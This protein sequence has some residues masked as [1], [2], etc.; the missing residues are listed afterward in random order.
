VARGETQLFSPAELKIY[1]LIS[2]RDGIKAREI[3]RELGLE[4]SEISRWMVSSALMRELCYQDKEY[5]WHAL[6]RQRPPYEGL[7]EFS[8]WY[9]TVPEF[10]A[11]DEETWLNELEQGCRRIGR[12]LND[13]RG[14]IHSFRDCRETMR[15]LF[16]DLREM[17]SLNT[18]SWEIVFE[19]RLNLRRMIRIYA[20][21]LVITPDRVF[22]LE[23]KMKNAVDPA[24]VLQ[25]A[26]YVPYLEILFGSQMD[27]F[28]ALVL[29]GATELFTEAPIGKTDFVLPVCSGDMLFNVFNEAIGFLA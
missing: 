28:P 29:T 7:Y 27:V 6:V 22:P 21:V 26:K 8:G 3:A 25:A 11:E 1:S 13:T 5:H 4:K 24:E 9:G 10:M 17:S 19:L 16:S 18:S 2:R 12:N 14:L 20:D 23:F 15:R